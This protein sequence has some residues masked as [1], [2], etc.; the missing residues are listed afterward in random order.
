MPSRRTLL[1]AAAALAPLL[2][3]PS[4]FAGSEDDPWP[5]IRAALFADRPIGDGD[6]ILSLEAPKRAHDAA[7][8]PIRVTAAIPQAPERYIAA[9]HLV[10]DKN[11]APVAGVFRF[12]VDSGSASFA[13]RVRIN[14]YTHLR[15]IAEMNDG[16]LF[17]AAAFVKAAGGCSAPALKDA[18]QALA[19]LGRMKLKQ[20]EPIVLDR[21][22]QAQL[23]ISHPNF[24][25]L[26]FDQVSRNYIP[27]H[28]VQEIRVRYGDR[29]VLLVEGNISLSEDPSVHFHFVPRAP[30]ALT[31]DV[32]DSDGI[33]FSQTWPVT[34]VPGS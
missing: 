15:A 33:K 24:S 14:E 32:T 12:T 1:W 16:S 21:P 6:G 9:V 26:Q 22:S 3:A 18:E 17:M 25:G 8:V 34:P 13:T 29:L 19:N 11:P 28:F 23:L 2:A 31:V 10:I 20:G 27:P 30:A 4:G 7:I 5:D